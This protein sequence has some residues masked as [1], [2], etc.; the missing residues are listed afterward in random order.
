MTG[1]VVEVI[2]IG[3][4]LGVVLPDWAKQHLGV[5]SGD[6]LAVRET[7]AGVELRPEPAE[8]R[9]LQR[10]DAGESRCPQAA[11]PELSLSSRCESFFWRNSLKEV[12]S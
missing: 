10:V 2:A 9:A 7:P 1:L 4:E 5:E 12:V 11:C 3:D 6:E 8:A